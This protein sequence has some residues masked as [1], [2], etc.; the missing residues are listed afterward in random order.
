MHGVHS[1]GEEAM[2]KLKPRRRAVVGVIGVVAGACDDDVSYLELAACLRLELMPAAPDYTPGTLPSVQEYL[3]RPSSRPR[4]DPTPPDCRCPAVS[5][6]WRRRLPPPR[7]EEMPPRQGYCRRGR[8]MEPPAPCVSAAAQ[9]QESEQ[10]TTVQAPTRSWPC[11]LSWRPMSCLT[12]AD[13]ML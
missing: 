7:R 9:L 11:T 4:L 13:C 10:T 8:E 5:C 12:L 2:T 6:Y 3:A 1:R